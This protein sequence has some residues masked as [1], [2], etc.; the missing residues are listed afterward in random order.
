MGHAPALVELRE[1]HFNLALKFEN[2]IYLTGDPEEV[3]QFDEKRWEAL[4]AAILFDDLV[5]QGVTHVPQRF[6]GETNA[7]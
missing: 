2:Y 6:K 5:R 4:D 1:L 7:R 3:W